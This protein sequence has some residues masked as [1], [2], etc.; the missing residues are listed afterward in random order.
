MKIGF[1]MLLW[2]P[3]VTEEH[4]HLFEPLKA[5]GYDGVE[6]DIFE[7]TPEHYAKV[8][9][10]LDDIG[11]ERTGVT[12]MPNEKHNPLSPD[13]ALRRAA[14]DHMKWAIECAAA[15]GVRVLAG[16]FYQPLG[17][18]SGRGPTEDEKERAAEAHREAADVAAGAGI[19]LCVEPL[20]RFECYFLNTIADA[21]AHAMRVDRPNFGIMYDTFHANLEERDPVGCIAEHIDMIRHVHVSENDRGTPGRGHV[22]WAEIFRALRK[23]GYDGWLTIEAFGR[24]L[25]ELAA[26]TCVWRDLSGSAEE[27]YTEGFRL[28]SDQWEAAGSPV[29]P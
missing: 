6:L 28:I 22:P 26:T 9:R 11:L 16:P 14:A 23:G 5:T 10:A 21:A 1:N 29:S 4:F 20:N 3:F 25:P 13:A 7:G 15:L 27:V 2:T 24:T 8:A 17:K 12:I 18:F 19:A